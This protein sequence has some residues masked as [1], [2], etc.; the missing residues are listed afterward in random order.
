MG[1]FGRVNAGVGGG[2]PVARGDEVAVPG[3]GLGNEK[4][5]VVGGGLDPAPPLGWTKGGVV[6]GGLDPAPPAGG[7]PVG[8]G[9][10]GRR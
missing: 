6:G 7:L 4:G 10:T 1:P 5:G 9:D 3:C 8:G 2:G